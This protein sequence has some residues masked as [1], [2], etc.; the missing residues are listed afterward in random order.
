VGE[1]SEWTSDVNST[2]EER[3]NFCKGLD[4]KPLFS[5]LYVLYTVTLNELKSVQKVTAQAGQSGIMN[6]SSVEST[7]HDDD[8][9]EVR[10]PKRHTSNDTSQTAKKST[11]PVPTSTAVKLPP[12]AMFTHNFFAPLRTA[13]MDMDTTITENTIPEQEAPRKPGRP[14]PIV[15]ISTKN[16]IQ[17]QRDLKD[18]VK[19][20]YEF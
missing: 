14:P 6:K 2:E 8:F 17:L 4:G 3:E 10:R 7:A 18:H 12:K 20:E 19:G 1:G 16:L 5:T 13:D 9:Q 15:M 11:K